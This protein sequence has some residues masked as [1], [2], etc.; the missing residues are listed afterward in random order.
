[1]NKVSFLILVLLSPLF[2]K[3]FVFDR[4]LSL[5]A[6][7]EDVRQLQIILNKDPLTRVALSGPGSVGNETNYFGHMTRAAVI[8]FQELYAPE[9]LFPIGLYKGT[10][11]IGQYTLSKLNNFSQNT[12]LGSPVD[13][14]PVSSIVPEGVVPRQSSNNLGTSIIN[15]VSNNLAPRVLGLS[16]YVASRGS[17]V[18]IFGDNF[19]YSDNTIYFSGVTKTVNSLSSKDGTTLSFRVPDSFPYGSY[20][21]SVINKNGNSFDNSFGNY[22]SVSE[23]EKDLPEIFS[24]EPESVNIN[25]QKYIT[26]KGENFDKENNKVLSSLGV[27]EG[28]SSLDGKTMKI[29]LADLPFFSQ[30]ETASKNIKVNN[31]S[32]DVSL[33]IQTSVGFSSGSHSIR[34]EF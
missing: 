14:N 8:K 28:V 27:L 1:M 16:R 34:V 24:I 2:L 22:F 10:G 23:N 20:N 7:G 25:D 30:L 17:E 19:N 5:G 31:Y 13:S 29:D 6:Q 26:I 3:A 32:F 4:S 21:L 9:V 33:N 12:G 11:F 15:T 18:T